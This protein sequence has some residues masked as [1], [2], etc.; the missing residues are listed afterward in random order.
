MMKTFQRLALILTT[1]LAVTT[2]ISAAT[3]LTLDA[4]SVD[5]EV[6]GTLSADT[7]HKTG[8]SKVTLSG[9]G[10]LFNSIG[11]LDIQAGTVSIST[12]L[13]LHS[14]MPAV[15][16]TSSGGTL[17]ITGAS[18]QDEQPIVATV[19]GADGTFNVSEGITGKLGTV[20]GGNTLTKAG[21][22]TLEISAGSNNSSST[23]E[24]SIGAGTLRAL[25][26]INLPAKT[27]LNGGILSLAHGVTTAREIAMAANS[28]VKVNS[29]ESATLGGVAA[30]LTGGQTLTK[31]GPGTLALT[32]DKSAATTAFKVDQG[33]LSISA[34]NQ[35]PAAGAP[36]LTLNG[37]TLKTTAALSLPLDIALA[38]DSTLDT[39]ANAVTHS[40]AITDATGYT[41][42]KAGSGSLTL[43]AINDTSSST[44]AVNAGTLSISAANQLPGASLVLTGGTLATTADL[45]IA[46]QAITLSAD[47]T[48]NTTGATVISSA[49]TE[50]GSRT[51]TKSGAGSLAVTYADGIAAFTQIRVTEGT[52]IAAAT[53]HL[54]ATTMLDGG[55]LSLAAITSE[56]IVDLSGISGGTVTV[57]AGTATQSGNITGTR[58]LTKNG[59]GT[60]VLSGTG[61]TAPLNVADGVLSIGSMDAFPQAITTIAAAKTLTTTGNI[62]A[63]TGDRALTMNST[64][65]LNLGGDFAAA[66]TIS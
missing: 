12:T 35:L 43:A 19:T 50:T 64:S 39:A 65:V 25:A 14:T 34:S 32:G 7:I 23:S 40:H 33:I 47:S 20:T 15:S 44:I 31:T 27:T 60:L 49:L 5:V 38:A 24:I 18:Q 4:S 61:N 11:N 42:T 54:P 37:G 62:V 48:I 30:V 1:S 41:L 63:F 57:A 58:T 66:I 51:L 17:A 59:A 3:E 52:L 56:R 26:G 9:A 45:T 13:S 2:Q 46:Q 36:S 21:L 55:T 6:S 53:N 22:G 29:G 10:S 16:F 8:A 28:S